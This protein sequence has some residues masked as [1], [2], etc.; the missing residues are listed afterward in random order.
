MSGIG[1]TAYAAEDDVARIDDRYYNSLNAARD[2]LKSNGETITLLEDIDLGG[3]YFNVPAL[4]EFEID[5]NGYTLSNNADRTLNL[6]QPGNLRYKCFLTIKDS[7]SAKTGKIINN[8][9]NV[10]CFEDGKFVL[11]SGT[12]QANGH[13]LWVSS[14]YSYWNISPTING[15][16]VIG[17][18]SSIG[19]VR[20]K[21][22]INGGR[23]NDDSG[24]D[25]KLPEGQRLFKEDDG[26]YALHDIISVSFN[27]G[28]GSGTMDNAEAG[29]DAPYTLP[30]AKFTAPE[31][32]AFDGWKIGI[33]DEVRKAGEKV[34]LKD[35]TTLTACWSS[36]VYTVHLKAGDGSGTMTDGLAVKGGKYLLPENEFECPEYRENYAGWKVEGS[37]ELKQAGDLI[38][39]TKDTTIIA[40][41]KS[42]KDF[43]LY[44]QGI[45]VNGDNYKDVLGELDGAGATVS[46]DPASD[47]LTLNNASIEAASIWYED[48]ATP[49]FGIITTW[50][51]SEDF[52]I[53]LK[54]NNRIE[55]KVRESDCEYVFGIFYDAKYAGAIT[56]NG[57]LTIDFTSQVG[58]S[59]KEYDGII[60]SWDGDLTIDGATISIKTFGPKE[61]SGICPVYEDDANNLKLINAAKLSIETESTE[62]SSK[63]ISDGA[64]SVS[65]DS[66]LEVLSKGENA[67]AIYNTTLSD[68]TKALGASVNTDASR[69]GASEWDTETDIGTYK[70]VC[71]PYSFDKSFL[72]KAIKAAQN[73]QNGVKTS[74][75]GKD[76]DPKQK[77][78]T[79][80]EK[81]ALQ[82]AIK[83]AQ[84]VLNKKTATQDEVDEA[85]S[86]L[87]TATATYNKAKKAGTKPDG[88]D[89]NQK[90]KDGTA[91]GPGASEAAAD[92]AITGMTTDGDPKGSKYAPLKLQSTKQA[93][94]NIT[95][96]WTKP[97][98]ATKYVLYGNK[99]GKKNKMKK[100]GTYTGKSKKLTKVAGKK[101]KK[102]TYYKFIIVALDKNNC[103]V[104]T[105]KVI[106]VTTKGG[107]YNN[108]KKVTTKKPKAL[109]KG[110][111][112]K[113]KAK[114][115][116]KK[117][118]KHRVLSYESS[119]TK[120]ATVSK[121]GVIKAKAKGTCYVY[122]YAQNGISK[123]VKVTVK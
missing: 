34:I 101:L 90:G 115:T 120:V 53:V 94:T 39:I 13:G 5:L 105:S 112:F 42:S 64:L 50:D 63:G 91:V 43:P 3:D 122:A 116:G 103:V 59:V 47:T 123:K 98:G 12:L 19:G 15:G 54:G 92:K 78:T 58:D 70:Y 24:N 4:Y 65:E 85:T 84:D 62:A 55:D 45:Q 60:N 73:A 40:Q 102:G 87:E 28:D 21:A 56:G 18:N 33:N 8:G 7:S 44:V 93:K 71:I 2:D 95:V 75:N 69:K 77:W 79:A 99:C 35:D 46:Y 83:T 66:A 74:T 52:K 109:K 114:Q 119:N 32:S 89:P 25:C 30:Y 107:K 6:Y 86:A 110:Q 27:P 11:E 17:K 96:K 23:F 37:N 117:V 121:K 113:L 97:S 26:Y 61:S 108:P 67:V 31:G 82:D 51:V 29:K 38:D 48:Y 41:W 80:A 1:M 22:T 14:D 106:H 111:S 104:S 72:E 36:D 49:E 118:K 16:T 20:S 76:V 9:G 88:T 68:E 10:V 57:S 81:A 100:I